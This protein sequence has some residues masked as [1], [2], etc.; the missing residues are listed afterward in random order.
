MPIRIEWDN[1][2]QTIIRAT[3]DNW[4]TEE[5]HQQFDTISTM[6]RTSN[7]HIEGI[8]VLNL[9]GEYA[10][11]DYMSVFK[12]VVR[13]GKIPTIFVGLTRMQE[14][15]L[16]TVIQIYETDKPIAIVSTIEEARR[17]LSQN[18]ANA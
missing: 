11:R 14:M 9:D 17:I 15:M 8:I 16:Q 2:E 4:T 12:R 6:V 18:I 7:Q 3:G 10:K 5:F 1:P 13:I